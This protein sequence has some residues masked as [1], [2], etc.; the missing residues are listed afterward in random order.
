M[1]F[2]RFCDIISFMKSLEL[3]DPK[4]KTAA[5]ISYFAQK[6]QQVLV[7]LGLLCVTVILLTGLFVFKVTHLGL[8]YNLLFFYTVLITVFQLFRLFAAIL[9]PVILANTS[10]ASKDAEEHYWPVVSVVVPCMNEED[11]IAHTLEMCFLAHYPSEKLEV[12]VI[13]DG[14]TDNTAQEIAAVKAAHPELVVITFEKNRGKRH[15]MYEGFK[16]ARGEIVLQLDS[17]S[18]IEPHTFRNMILPFANEDIAAVCGHADVAN[19]DQ[20][21]ITKMQAGYYFV[22]FRLLKSAESV[23]ASVFCCSG[24][25]SAYRKSVVMPIMEPWLNERFMGVQVKHGDDRS[26][27][28]WVLKQGYKTIYTNRVQAYTIAPSTV[29]QLFKQQVRW[30]KSWVSNAYFTFTYIFKTDPFV[31]ALYFVPLI[32][33]SFLTPVVAFYN[34]YLLSIVHLTV[35]YMYLLG[36]LVIT[37]LYVLY[38][39]RYAKGEKRYVQYFFLWQLLTVTIFSY[40]IYYSFLRF[41]DQRWGTR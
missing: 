1:T 5:K 23:F 38:A 25:S 2:Y 31:G 12:I 11:A 17:D 4:V 15:G 30:K 34:L 19:A 13:N 21:M 8:G 41:R 28:G 37:A 33:I 39:W 29:K 3:I 24:C 18:Y 27:T 20:N 40:I 26:L 36:G 32:L 22:A 6:T 14:S 9:F 10:Y 16:V 7:D 35:P